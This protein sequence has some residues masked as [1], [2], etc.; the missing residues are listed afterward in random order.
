MKFGT[1]VGL[2]P[3]NIGLDGDPAPPIFGPCL[4]KPNDWM[5]KDATWYGDIGLDPGDIVLVGDPAAPPTKGTAAPPQFS[6]HV[7]CGQTAR[8]LKMPLGREADLSPGDIVLDGDPAY[9]SPERDHNT[10]C[11]RPMCIVPK[12]SPVSATAEHL[13]RWSPKNLIST[14]HEIF[15]TYYC[16]R[17]SVLF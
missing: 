10:P 1:E 13:Y 16:G 5:N 2:D 4:L 9:S 7:C 17:G 8:W 14:L 15:C 6:A 3:D 11:F 12:R